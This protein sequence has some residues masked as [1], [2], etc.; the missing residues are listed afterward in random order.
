MEW[1]V[2]D[3]EY[4]NYL[5]SYE[6]RIPR[7]D[8][9]RDK[10]KPFFGTLFE[11]EEFYYVSQISHVQERHESMKSNIDF[12]KIYNPEDNRLLA[13]INLNYMFPIPKQEKRALRYDEFHLHREFASEDEKSKYIDLL[14][15]ELRIMNNLDLE[16]AAWI[17]YNNKLTGKNE[18]LAK[19]SLDFKFMET[20][21]REYVVTK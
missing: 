1:L 17:V 7:S 12:K 15:K 4:L 20:L 16:G 11:T 2:I 21:A 3:E 14:K 19:R 9:G 18:R 5:R 6:K 13:V 8:Y 10:Y